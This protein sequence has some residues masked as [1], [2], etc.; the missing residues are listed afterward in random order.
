M[1]FSD[2]PL[3]QASDPEERQI[4]VQVL[5]IVRNYTQAFFD[6]SLLGEASPILESSAPAA[7][8]D[9]V[10]RFKPGKRP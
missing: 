8:V 3:L 2:L 4:A 5:E 9:D 10:R 1:S 7:F 6:K